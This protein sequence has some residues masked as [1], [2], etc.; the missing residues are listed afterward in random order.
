MD[1]KEKVELMVQ[2]FQSFKESLQKMIDIIKR[3]AKVVIRL[4]ARWIAINGG[5]SG[6]IY[7]RTK[8]S[9]IRNKHKKRMLNQFMEVIRWQDAQ[10]HDTI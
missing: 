6:K 7:L 9:R 10:Q 1:E 8:S 3:V 2:A 5:K 4:I